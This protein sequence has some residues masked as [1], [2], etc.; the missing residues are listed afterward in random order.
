MK[1]KETLGLV[2]EKDCKWPL[3][4]FK[5]VAMCE[6]EYMDD[7]KKGQIFSRYKEGMTDFDFSVVCDKEYF[8]AAGLQ[9]LIMKD[10]LGDNENP[11]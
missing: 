1:K 5:E 4:Y 9:Y 8:D 2:K 11:S 10:I 3:G 6:V 7:V